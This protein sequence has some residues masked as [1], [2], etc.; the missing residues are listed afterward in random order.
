MHTEA[1]GAPVPGETTALQ[2]KGNLIGED[3]ALF[4]SAAFNAAPYPVHIGG[5]LD[6]HQR[7][8]QRLADCRTQEQSALVFSAYME[9][10]FALGQPRHSESDGLPRFRPSYVELLRT[11]GFD[12]NASAGAVLKAWVESRFGLQPIYHKEVLGRFPS[13]A[14]IAYL[15]EKN[16]SR[17]HDNLIALQ[18]DLLYEYGQWVL[19]RFQ[20]PG[21]THLGLWRGTNDIEGQVGGARLDRNGTPVFLNNLVS[22]SESSERA[23]EFGCWILE[24]EVPLSKIVFYPGMLNDRVLRS[25]RE[26]LVIGGEYMARLHRGAPS[27]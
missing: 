17:F 5:T 21:E 4:A 16:G 26:Y 1:S 24:I 11:W 6:V 27:Q 2:F 7:L 10:Y 8:F 23:E 14:W 18:L 19:R 13:G 12:S 20:H 9:D 3:S 25:E 15:E 22:F